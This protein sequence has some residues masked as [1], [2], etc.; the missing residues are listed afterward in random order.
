VAL[1]MIRWLA[2]ITLVKGQILAPIV[3]ITSLVGAYAID[4][5]PGDVMVAASMGVIGYLMVRFH[6]PRLPLVMALVLGETAERGFMQ[7]MMIG[8]GN[9]GI[10]VSSPVS[11][12]MVL[13]IVITL[14]WWLVPLIR[15][16]MQ[17]VK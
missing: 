16:R 1:V 10:F 11:I 17:G 3:I 15:N 12:V 6:Y 9:W 2:L 14:M 8:R 13:L 5:R 4:S 7:S